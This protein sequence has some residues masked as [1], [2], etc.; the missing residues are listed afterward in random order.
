MN[1]L[2]DMLIKIQLITA[3]RGSQVQTCYL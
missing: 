2:S 3:K 1:R